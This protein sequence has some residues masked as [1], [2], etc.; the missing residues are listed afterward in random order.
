MKKMVDVDEQRYSYDSWIL[1]ILI[2][3]QI[4]KYKHIG[5]VERPYTSIIL[6]RLNT[7]NVIDLL[8]NT[9]I[10]VI[11]V[12]NCNCEL[13]FKLLLDNNIIAGTYNRMQPGSSIVNACFYD[14][15]DDLVID[16][17][18][19]M[20]LADRNNYSD[21]II[22]FLYRHIWEISETIED[23]RFEEYYRGKMVM[24]Q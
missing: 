19:D 11:R 10:A 20:I 1:P 18:H 4:L 22:K 5:Y 23:K 8:T 24:A 7:F 15:F 9:S 3:E 21:T 12:L 16:K 13:D 14:S 2:G 6:S 17:D